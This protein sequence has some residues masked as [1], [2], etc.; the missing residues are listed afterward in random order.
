MKLT[1]VICLKEILQNLW[2]KSLVICLFT[3]VCFLH[4]NRCVIVHYGTDMEA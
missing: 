4:V 2:L 3:F 1:F